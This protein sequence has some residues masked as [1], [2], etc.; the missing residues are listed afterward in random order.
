MTQA[1][2]IRGSDRERFPDESARNPMI[3]GFAILLLFFGGIGTWAATAP[4][5]AAV[6]GDAVVK[7]EGN[8]KSVQHIN[9]GIVS[10]LLVH[11]GDRV[12]ADQV[13]LV[14]DDTEARAEYDIAMQQIT[15]LQAEEARL[16][17]ERD[18]ESTISFPADLVS[19]SGEAA[20]Q[21]AMDAQQDEFDSRRVALAGQAGILGQRLLQLR[22]QI[23]AGESLL[24]SQRTQLQSVVDERASLE[25]LFKQGLVTKPRMLQLERTATGLEGQIATTTGSIAT[26]RK[27]LQEIDGQI[28]Q[29]RNDRL[30][31][32]TKELGEAQAKLQDMA[33]RLT[34]A[35]A[36]LGRMEVRA[37]YAGEVVD[38]AVFSVG[39]VIGRGE[40]ILD[41]VPQNTILVVESKVRVEDIADIA[42]GMRAE[43]HFTSYKQRVTPLIHGNVKAI[44]ADRL[45]DERTQIPYYVAE[46]AVDA[47]ELAENPEIQLY[48]GMPATVTITTKERTALDYLLAPL[49]A[50]FERSFREK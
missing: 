5:N 34:N 11:E 24:Q 18:G 30:A 37:P 42:P 12:A 38:L 2:A 33:P 8:R 20:V 41:I 39:A 32:V 23:A 31:E 21:S 47:A 3:A 19:R 9:G 36:S 40:R 15:T 49:T 48:P 27:T 17:A 29:L 50:S 25:G 26:N 10:E 45:T 28:L 1:L 43:V 35:A 4:L 22:D 14:L 44:S 13:L 7:V 16:T 46:I 6:V